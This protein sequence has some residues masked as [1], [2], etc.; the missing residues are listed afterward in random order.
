MNENLWEREIRDAQGLPPID[1]KGSPADELPPTCSTASRRRPAPRP[2]ARRV[3][4]SPAS[5]AARGHRSRRR[6][7]RSRRGP[8]RPPARH[9]LRQ[10]A[11]R[12][13][14]QR[15]LRAARRLPRHRGDRLERRRGGHPGGRTARPRC[16][17]RSVPWWVWGSI[18]VG[19]GLA[20]VTII[21]PTA[22]PHHRRPLRR[23][24]GRVPRGHL[25]PVQRAVGRH[26]PAG[27]RH[28]RR[29]LR[30]HA[31]PVRHP[32]HPGHREG[33]HGDHRGHLGRGALLPGGAGGLAVRRRTCRCSTSRRCWA[34]ASAC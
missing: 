15:H 19:F 29:H 33:A 34:S 20:I 5:P 21:K 7:T 16:V 31:V 23:R 22:R 13:G 4:P 24:R 27:R 11:R 32:H 14:G 17:S 18:F 8:R 10:D 6:P 30:R 25:A 1:R 3:D 28:D 2:R 26:R 12:R 9:R